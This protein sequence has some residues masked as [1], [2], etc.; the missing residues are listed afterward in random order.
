M[1]VLLAYLSVLSMLRRGE[2]RRAA[3]VLALGAASALAFSLPALLPALWPSRSCTGYREARWAVWLIP[4]G[5]A[6]VVAAA[7]WL[8]RSSPGANRIPRWGFL[9]PVAFLV[10]A[11]MSMPAPLGW[12][13]RLDRNDMSAVLALARVRDC[14][15]DYAAKDPSAG[16]PPSLASCSGARAETAGHVIGFE[17]AAPAGGRID[18]Y[19]VSAQ[20]RQWG[21]TSFMSYWSDESGVLRSELARPTRPDSGGRQV[22]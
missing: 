11:I 7:L 20:P 22:P 2:P 21:C 17:P 3:G 15:R 6:A 14:S 19:R 8:R 16:Y 4:T 10:A 1:P 18:R 12:H 5:Q 13:D 9:G